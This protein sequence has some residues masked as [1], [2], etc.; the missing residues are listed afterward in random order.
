MKIP[1]RNTIYVERHSLD[2]FDVEAMGTPGHVVMSLLRAEELNGPEDDPEELL[3]EMMNNIWYVCAAVVAHPRAYLHMEEYGRLVG[4]YYASSANSWRR[5]DATFGAVYMLLTKACAEKKGVKNFL[6]GM[7]DESGKIF[8]QINVI[9]RMLKGIDWIKTA[10]SPDDFAGR[11]TTRTAMQS[12]EQAG[13]VVPDARDAKIEELCAKL[14]KRNRQLEEAQQRMAEY[15]KELHELDRQMMPMP[16]DPTKIMLEQVKQENEELRRRL[17][18]QEVQPAD[19]ILKDL[20]DKALYWSDE[21]CLKELLVWLTTMEG[22]ERAKAQAKRVERRLKELKAPV[23][24]TQHNYYAGANHI[25]GSEL[26]G[27]S[28]GTTPANRT[29][30]QE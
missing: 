28:I 12:K 11:P 23:P 25:S 21:T 24:H 3:L 29:L 1:S 18:E 9:H 30:T 7:D 4:K 14:E 26:K 13:G 10:L 6:L 27:V 8:A 19:G 20:V 5:R 17:A 2:D 22:A 15:V 16:Y